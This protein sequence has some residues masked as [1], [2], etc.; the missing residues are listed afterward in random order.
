MHCIQSTCYLVLALHAAHWNMTPLHPAFGP[1][2]CIRRPMCVACVTCVRRRQIETVRCFVTLVQQLA[3]WTALGWYLNPSW[4]TTTNVAMAY[5]QGH[6]QR[7]VCIR[8]VLLLERAVWD[9]HTLCV[10]PQ[11]VLHC[12]HRSV[13]LNQVLFVCVAAASELVASLDV[14]WG[15]GLRAVHVL[16]YCTGRSRLQMFSLPADGSV[17]SSSVIPIYP[18]QMW[19]QGL[20]PPF[21]RNPCVVP[22]QTQADI[23][24]VKSP[25]AA[26]PY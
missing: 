13:R 12:T 24:S 10:R 23:T 5:T 8:I 9:L 1:C 19:C 11:L 22:P 16:C 3:M 25:P 7:T 17:V 14:T 26:T 18:L 20:V 4:T 21:E 6:Q 2:L 15:G